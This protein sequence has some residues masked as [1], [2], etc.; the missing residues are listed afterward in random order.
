MSVSSVLKR[1]SIDIFAGAF[2]IL[3]AVWWGTHVVAA[4]AVGYFLWTYLSYRRE[5]HLN[6]RHSEPI[7]EQMTLAEVKAIENKYTRRDDYSTPEKRALVRSGLDR[8]FYYVRYERVQSLLNAFAPDAERVLDMGCGFGRNTAHVSEKLRKL[9]IG[10]DL[11][12]LKL[13]WACNEAHRREPDGRSAFVCADAARPPLRPRSFNCI[14]MTEVLEHLINPAEGLAACHELLEKAGVLIITVPSR[15]NLAY[16]TN[17]FIFLEKTLSLINNRVLPPYHNLHARSE[18]NWRRPEP[19][20][21]MHHNF[22]R[23]RLGHLVHEAGFRTIRWGSFEVEIFPYLLVEHLSGG[24]VEM[25]R[26]WVSPIEDIM[27]RLPVIGN[28]GQHLIWVG[29]KA[30]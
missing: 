5:A 11:D 19:E 13:S 30:T 14:V 18:Y 22:S 17:P 15:H 10:L 6:H 20:Y 8:Y 4:C 27:T 2:L 9:A 29:R 21:G 26:R 16:S 3:D 24:D 28:M 23:Q 25:I 12:E 1:C 7:R